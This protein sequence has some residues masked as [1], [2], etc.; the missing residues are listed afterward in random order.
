MWSNFDT[1]ESIEKVPEDRSFITFIFPE[2]ENEVIFHVPVLRTVNSEF[3]VFGQNSLGESCES[4]F[5]SCLFLFIGEFRNNFFTVLLHP[6]LEC[7]FGHAWFFILKSI[8]EI[9]D[10]LWGSTSSS[11]FFLVFILSSESITTSNINIILSFDD[12]SALNFG[13]D[14]FESFGLSHF[15]AVRDDVNLFSSKVLVNSHPSTI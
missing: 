15:V 4:F 3:L 7:I 13:D 10:L 14:S 11:S 1:F 6:V 2:A 12:H 5:E 8:N 9:V